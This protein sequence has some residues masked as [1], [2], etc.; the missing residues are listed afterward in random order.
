MTHCLFFCCCWVWFV[1]LSSGSSVL[2]LS[3]FWGWGVG[4]ASVKGSKKS[5][6]SLCSS[7]A[8]LRLCSSLALYIFLRSLFSPTPT[9]PSSHG[10]P[11]GCIRTASLLVDGSEGVVLCIAFSVSS[12]QVCVWVCVFSSSGATHVSHTYSACFSVPVCAFCVLFCF[13][14]LCLLRQID[15]FLC[16]CLSVCV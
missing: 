3:F 2:C 16:V 4:T 8:F 12:L 5:I 7:S 1:A 11:I 13:F 9:P 10:V 14:F 15:Y 6:L